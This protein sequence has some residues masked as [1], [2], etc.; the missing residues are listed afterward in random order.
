MSNRRS[1]GVRFSIRT[2]LL[3]MLLLGLLCSWFVSQTRRAMRQQAAVNRVRQLGGNVTYEYQSDPARRGQPPPTP[4]PALQRFT[5]LVVLSDVVKVTW[6]ATHANDADA[7]ALADLPQLRDLRLNTSRFSDQATRSLSHLKR[8]RRLDL[9]CSQLT[10]RTL[11]HLSNLSELR[12]LDLYS[13]QVSDKGLHHLYGLKNL[14]ELKLRDTRVTAVGAAKLQAA[15][16]N[17]K[18]LGVKDW[19]GLAQSP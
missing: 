2:L 15:L 3:A 1:I 11:P 14:K 19:S 9:W 5:G 17:C 18:I 8:L 7:A 12:Q 6:Q 16:P 4:S 13:T 10:D